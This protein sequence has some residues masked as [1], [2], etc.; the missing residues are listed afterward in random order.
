MEPFLGEIR[1]VGFNYAP[2]GWALCDGSLIAIRSNTALFSI[3]GTQYGGNGQTTFALPDL[4][5]RAIV[6]AGTG[7]G[8]SQYTVGETTGVEAVTLTQAQIPAHTHGLDGSVNVNAVAGNNSSPGGNYLSNSA[9]PQYAE[10]AGTGT[11]AAGSVKGTANVVGGDQP[12]DNLQPYLALYYVIAVQGIF[13]Q[14]S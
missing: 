2:R 8:L 11:M 9:Q 14:R 3:L 6:T 4:R 12:H 10:A 13:P 1:A 7:A 5:S